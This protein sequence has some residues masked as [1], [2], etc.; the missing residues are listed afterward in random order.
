M[1]SRPIRDDTRK[2]SWLPITPLISD[3]TSSFSLITTIVLSKKTTTVL[4]LFRELTQNNCDQCVLV[5]NFTSSALLAAR[6]RSPQ[7]KCC[8]KFRDPNHAAIGFDHWVANT[9]RLG[10]KGIRGAL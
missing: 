7:L 2:Q 10:D 1:R 6:E 9:K 8:L 4:I 3:P 5:A